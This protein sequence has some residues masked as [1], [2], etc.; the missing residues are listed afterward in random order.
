MHPYTPST[1]HFFRLWIR[2]ATGRPFCTRPAR[3]RLPL[4]GENRRGAGPRRRTASVGGG[5][6]AV[7]GGWSGAGSDAIAAFMVANSVPPLAEMS[8]SARAAAL[9]GEH[10]GRRRAAAAEWS[11][12]S[13]SSFEAERGARGFLGATDD[14]HGDLVA[15]AGALALERFRRDRRRRLRLRRTPS[16]IAHTSP[17][18]SES[19]T[20]SVASTTEHPLAG[21]AA[22]A[23]TG[24]RQPGAAV[25]AA[26]HRGRPAT[27]AAG[28]TALRRRVRRLAEVGAVAASRSDCESKRASP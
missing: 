5:I 19:Q 23:P 4:D 13:P 14:H 12:P 17:A 3:R 18:S 25:V 16:A 6:A 24:R 10:D 20:P 11:G 8:E 27:R 9:C 2:A 7:G 21:I 28:R 26:A 22:C 15:H 1:W